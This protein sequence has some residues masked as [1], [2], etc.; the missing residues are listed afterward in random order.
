[1]ARMCAL[2]K[3]ENFK[4]IYYY[5]LQYGCLINMGIAPEDKL[6]FLKE[7]QDIRKICDKILV[8]RHDFRSNKT[9]IFKALD[10]VLNHASSTSIYSESEDDVNKLMGD[11]S[12]IKDRWDSE[13]VDKEII[14]SIEDFCSRANSLGICEKKASWIS[15]ISVRINELKIFSFSF[16]G[17]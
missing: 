10:Q 11:L 9:E 17:K 2:A 15:K 12:I 5:I 8:L 1:M 16:L 3:K 14:S 6:Q 7:K 13:G 4:L